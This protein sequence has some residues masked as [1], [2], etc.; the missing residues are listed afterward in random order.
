MPYYDTVKTT[1]RKESGVM[2][3]CHVKRGGYTELV[4]VGRYDDP[5]VVTMGGF[6][7]AP[8]VFDHSAFDERTARSEL[9]NAMRR[10]ARELTKTN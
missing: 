8:V 10:R 6:T 3:A 9:R 1:Y 5:G 4:A 2:F 7:D